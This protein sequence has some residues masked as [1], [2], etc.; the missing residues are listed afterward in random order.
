MV[1]VTNETGLCTYLSRDWEALTGQTLTDA[2]NFGWTRVLHP[3]DRDFVRDLVLEAIEQQCAFH[4]RYRVRSLD[5]VFRWVVAGAVPSFGPP[6]R[7]FLGFFGSVTLLDA[8]PHDIL[9]AS[10][11]LRPTEPIVQPGS[12]LEQAAD[13]LLAAHSLISSSASDVTLVALERALRR[14]GEDLA[15]EA[16]AESGTRPDLQ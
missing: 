2:R 15:G 9:S 8:T 7:T 14:L 1:F 3:D 4:V 16:L 13:H 6:Q 5:R 10:G 12:A 11:C